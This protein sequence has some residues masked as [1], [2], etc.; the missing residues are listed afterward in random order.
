MEDSP[1]SLLSRR[2]FLAA[3]SLTA[4]ALVAGCGGAE[5]PAAA[6]APLSS[7][8]DPV[9]GVLDASMATAVAIARRERAPFG[10]VLVD[11]Q[12]GKI[13]A[14]G[15]NLDRVTGDPSAHAEVVLLRNAGM[16]GVDFANTVMVTTAESCPMCAACAVWAGIAGVAYGTPAAFLAAHGW[17]QFTLT[18]PEVVAAGFLSM[19]VVGNVLRAATDALYVGGPPP[20]VT[21]PAAHG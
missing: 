2:A 9:R 13:V 8:P 17:H 11:T 7:L 1:R 5:A 15:G 20:P 16:A 14:R 4:A 6:L 19:P 3:G 10:A 21:R 18:Q 12:T